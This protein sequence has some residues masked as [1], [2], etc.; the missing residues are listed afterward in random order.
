MSPNKSP[1]DWQNHRRVIKDSLLAVLPNLT[2]LINASFAPGI[3]P[4]SCKMAKVSPMLKD[5]NFDEL[6]N[7]I[8]GR[9]KIILYRPI[10]L[11]AMSRI[12]ERIAL[13]PL[14]P[15]LLLNEKLSVTQSGN[16]KFHSTEASLHSY[17]W[18]KLAPGA[19]KIW[20]YRNEVAAYHKGVSWSLSF[21]VYM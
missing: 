14:M 10:S 9:E 15:Y 4:R 18:P 3:F 11:L 12:S 2:S 16:K 17:T 6:P 5:G 20:D 19:G 1:E 8:T 13:N 21:S 7:I